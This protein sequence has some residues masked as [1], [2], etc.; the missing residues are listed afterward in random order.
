MFLLFKRIL[1]RINNRLIP[2]K[3]RALVWGPGR[4]VRG[5]KKNMWD[6]I[7]KSYRIV[8]YL[9]YALRCK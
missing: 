3:I 4:M 8:Q 1:M 9:R 7:I 2:H 6:S 5:S